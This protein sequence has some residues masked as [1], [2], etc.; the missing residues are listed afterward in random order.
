MGDAPASPVPAPVQSTDPSGTTAAI[1]ITEPAAPGDEVLGEGGKKALQSER[2]ARKELEARLKEL[3]PLAEAAKAAEEANKSEVQK[4]TE[5]LVRE[6]D[7]RKLAE[8][9][10]M[11]QTVGAEKGVPAKLIKFLTG[12]TKAEVEQAADELLSEL[13]ATADAKPSMP[14]RPTERLVNGKPSGSKL[15][16]M[17]P[18]TLIRMGRGQEPPK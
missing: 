2:Q 17:D 3:E 12:S 16:S 4:A 18:M 1:T 5:A 14:G 13:G 6:R 10:L 11:I 7:A 9:A 15:D 8:T